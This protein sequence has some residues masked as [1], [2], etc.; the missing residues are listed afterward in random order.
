MLGATP[1]NDTATLTGRALESPCKAEYQS[2]SPQRNSAPPPYFFPLLPNLS[3]LGVTLPLAPPKP[4]FCALAA[5]GGAPASAA[6]CSFLGSKAGGMGSSAAAPRRAGRRGGGVVPGWCEG[7]GGRAEVAYGEVEGQQLSSKAGPRRPKKLT[8][9]RFIF[10]LDVEY[11]RWG[12]LKVHKA[13]A[14][15]GGVALLELASWRSLV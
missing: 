2:V 1:V 6:A 3:Q 13:L 10:P 4:S 5:F 15:E 11:A 12:E 8:A 14:L 7:W 9:E